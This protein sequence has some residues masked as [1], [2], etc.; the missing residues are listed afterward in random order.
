MRKTILFYFAGCFLLS[1]SAI[2]AQTTLTANGINPV[3]GQNF[4]HIITPYYSPG[5]SGPNQTWD[6][7]TIS[8]TSG[9]A[10]TV[11]SPSSTPQGYNFP[12]ANVAISNTTA[13][14]IAYYKT[15]SA[16]LQ[17]YGINVIS[18]N[19]NIVFSNP[20]DYLRFPFIYNNTY[21]DPFYAQ[22][23]SNGY[24]FYRYGTNTVTADGYGTLV[25]PSGTFAN[26]LRIHFVQDYKDSADVS[27]SAYIVNYYND[28]YLWYKDGVNGLQLAS[29]YIFDV[30]TSGTYTG[31]SYLPGGLGIADDKNSIETMEI[32]PNPA[33][34]I[35]NI[36][37]CLADNQKTDIEILNSAGKT[38]NISESNECAAGLNLFQI[39]ISIL[40]TG[41][42]FVRV[43]VSGKVAAIRQVFVSQ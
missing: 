42:Y 17:L 6:F 8:G 41:I 34:H 16:A 38:T 25:T 40:P 24:Q 29:T 30:S 7:S 32:F 18:S 31:G 1:G 37:L 13:G 35:L 11:V 33:R 36:N 3:I 43:V 5:N 2:V 14:T 10:E 23:V 26:V 12:N 22:F 9:G 20:E 15:S 39:D 19:T 28:E 21:S 27:G 4:N